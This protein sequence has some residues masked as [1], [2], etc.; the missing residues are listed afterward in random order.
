MLPGPR[1]N[2]LEPFLPCTIFVESPIG[3][4]TSFYFPDSSRRIRRSP[5]SPAGKAVR[6]NPADCRRDRGGTSERSC[7]AA[8]LTGVRYG[9]RH[10]LW[11]DRSAA[12][13]VGASTAPHGADG[14]AYGGI[15]CACL[16]A[17]VPGRN[18]A[19]AFGGVAC[20]SPASARAAASQAGGSPGRAGVGQPS[21]CLSPACRCPT[22]MGNRAGREL[23]QQDRRVCAGDRVG[24]AAA[25]FVHAIRAARARDNLHGGEPCAAGGGRYFRIEGTLS[26]LR[27]RP[28]GR[29]L[30]GAL[31]YGLRHARGRVRPRHRKPHS[32]R[33][34]AAGGSHGDDR[35]FVA[36]R[37]ANSNGIGVFR[38]VRHAG[39]HGHDL[40]AV[41]GAGTAGGFATVRGAP[42]SVDQNGDAG[43]DRHLRRGRH[44]RRHGCAAVAGADPLRGVLAAV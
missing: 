34:P 7:R 5:Q 29:R 10:H 6:G 17:G 35:A 23:A 3:A 44:S 9:I 28:A 37:F 13:S 14:I 19:R 32:R 33:N 15:D 1:R 27:A 38:G 39:D 12:G 42:L 4:C 8:F 36:V 20:C 25:L 21:T 41:R 26:D 31:R 18:A 11:F 16:R 22:G 30:G 2:E 40:V 24:A 43:T